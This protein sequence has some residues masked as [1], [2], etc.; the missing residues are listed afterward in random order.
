MDFRKY[1]SDRVKGLGNITAQSALASV[2]G[3]PNEEPSQGPQNTFKLM[4]GQ[5]FEM[6]EDGGGNFSKTAMP[7]YKIE[8]PLDFDI[9]MVRRR[10]A[11]GEGYQDK[12]EAILGNLMG[13]KTQ[14][15]D[16]MKAQLAAALQQSKLAN[17]GFDKQAQKDEFQS[18]VQERNKAQKWLEIGKL[19]RAAVDEAGETGAVSNTLG[20]IGAQLGMPKQQERMAGNTRMDRLQARGIE[21]LKSAGTGT[22]TDKDMEKLMAAL[23]TSSKLKSQNL[24]AIEEINKEYTQQ[25]KVLDTAIELT[26]QG[27]SPVEARQ[28]AMQMVMSESVP[29][30]GLQG[31]AGVQAN[32]GGGGQMQIMPGES[33]DDFVARMMRRG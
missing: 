12:N 19:G 28:K 23:P 8:N 3:M 17:N 30:E 33:V 11:R 1:I 24:A 16:A 10:M 9:G 18:L 5:D 14:E 25:L 15:N 4:P 20:W 6:S 7:G 29:A 13:L 32:T 2:L 21:L 22:L 31:S 27:V 26:K